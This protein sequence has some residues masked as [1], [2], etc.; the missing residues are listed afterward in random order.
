MNGHHIG[1]SYKEIFVHLL[2]KYNR[3][4]FNNCKRG[5]SNTIACLLAPLAS[6]FFLRSLFRLGLAPSSLPLPPRAAA[7]VASSSSSGCR[8]RRFLFLLGL[9]PSS[10]PLP[11]RATALIASSS[12][13]LFRPPR[14]PFPLLLF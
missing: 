4:S 8:P 11:P 13:S 5:I 12:S 9:P 7:L 1:E 2:T 3:H 10:L 6:W 14:L